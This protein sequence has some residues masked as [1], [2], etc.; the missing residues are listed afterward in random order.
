[1]IL[2]HKYS[3]LAILSI[4]L[5]FTLGCTHS[6][7][8]S[9]S[10]LT[11]ESLKDPLGINTLH[12]RF[13]WKNNS[14]RQGA[15]QTAYQILVADDIQKLNEKD[16]DVWNSGK[17]TSSSNIWVEYAGKPL[18]PGQLL[19]WKVRVWD[20]NGNESSWSKPARFGVGLLDK[21]DWTASYIG[22]PSEKGF[23]SCP[24]LRKTF[25]LNKTDKKGAYLLHVNSLGYHEV[26]MNGKK[27]GEDVLSP[28][29]SQ[30]DKRSL[31]VT[32]DVTP[33]L[34][35]G[36]ND[37]VIWLGSGWYTEGLP[38]VAG[39]GP[40]VRAQ[41]EHVHK[42]TN[43]TVLYTDASW[44]GRESEYS[45]IS[46]WM[47]GRY[48]GETVSGN[49][50]TQHIVF[51]A[52]D[53]LKW[54]EIAIAEIPEHEVT[55]QTVE[56]NRIME[57]I[58]PAKIEK[59][60]DSTFLVDMGKCLTGWF[61]ITFPDLEK[62]QEIVM[63][64]A[65]HLDN[66]GGLAKQGQTDKY[67]ASGTG[68]E[69]FINKFNY[70]G[71]R[72]V[73]ISKLKQIPQ[74]TDIK[75]HLIHTD[76][77][78]TSTFECSDEDLNRIHDMIAYT[79]RCVGLGGY[80]VDCP[81]I[82]RL[83]Y[84]GDGNA[85]TVTAQ[86]MF[87][88]APLYNNWLQAWEDVIREDG[89]MPHT[90]PNPYAAGGGPYWCGFIISASWNT[91]QHYGDIRVLEKY[92]PVMKKWLEYVDN[93]SVNGL[94]KR[95]P[96]T[97]YRAWYLGDWAT[98]EGVGNPDHIDE[99]SVDLVNNCYISVCFDQMKNIAGVLGKTEE[100]KYYS[101]KRTQLNRTIHGTF[102]D[103]Q[104]GCYAT[105]SQIDFIF[106]MLAGVAPL[107]LRDQLTQTLKVRTE[108]EFNGHLNTGLVGIPIMMEWA[109]AADE[110]DFIYS[111]L[112][113]KT[114]P[115]YLY[116]LEQGATTTWEHWNGERSRIHNCFNG[117]GQWFYQA[118]GGIHSIPGKPAYSEFLVDP[119]I[120]EGVTWA[121]TTQETPYGKI[122]VHW[123]LH[124]ETMTMEVEVPVGSIAKLISPQSA[125]STRINQEVITDQSDTISLKSGKYFVE[126]SSKR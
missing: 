28:A 44:V 68:T 77:E 99:R 27:V 51:E 111:M 9:I 1:M 48:G 73:K 84:G 3:Q 60:N 78:F 74:L 2:T 57:T 13:N 56:P 110:P 25:S 35:T 91:Y 4:L 112:K 103:A 26:F 45:R 61:E 6:D 81:Q 66:N 64:Y 92:Y 83:G 39:N 31:I 105:G 115:G 120:P 96:D 21:N 8:F 79:L 86:T 59:L 15:I 54:G 36:K 94:L 101:E 117:V 125:I 55:P 107:E 121:K 38:G 41:M 104:Q 19:F 106:P 82:E 124:N 24:Q 50:E 80:L 5:I 34:R 71:F 18:H 42:G 65:D 75:A 43:E 102:F 40:V 70:H 7:R 114:Y 69:Y 90:A 30:F 29:V 17:I 10:D 23:Y 14:N 76:F 47:T 97:S 53:E 119:Q 100:A 67:I 116:M 58:Q 98:P 126:Y 95:W 93:H 63:E 85:S 49:L 88:L 113:K 62:S 46:D 123:E 12:P 89:S 20:E 32:Y 37:L 33:F 108:N 118:I 52:P 16:A 72:Y 87:H 122:G 22:Y 11:C 109:V